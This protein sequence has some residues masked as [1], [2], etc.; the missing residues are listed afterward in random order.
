MIV[1]CSNFV[2]ISC[3]GYFYLTHLFIYFYIVAWAD[4]GYDDDDDD[5]DNSSGGGDSGGY[6]VTP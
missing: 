4:D 6:I 3:V 5:G 2:S 1:S